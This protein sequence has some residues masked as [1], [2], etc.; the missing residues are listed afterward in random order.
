MDASPSDIR[1]VPV[2]VVG[3]G[4]N[5]IGTFR[6]LCL[7]G[8][9]CLLV[10]RGDL[11]GGASA[12]SSRLMHGGL[13]YLET[14]EFRLVRQSAEERNL[15]LRNA[16]HAVAPLET[17]LPVRS[18]FGGIVPSAR[19]FLGLKARLN[20]RGRLITA[21]GLTLYDIFGRRFRA[22]PVHRFVGRREAQRLLPG[23]DPGILAVGLYYEA[24]LDHAE[25]LGLE[26]A[27]DALAD[28]PGSGIR[29]YC[30]ARGQAGGVIEIEDRLTGRRERVT[31]D[32]VV[33]AGGAW[34]DDVNAALGLNSRYMGGTKG[35]H[36]VVEHPGLLAA[37]NGR[38]VYFGSA[39]GRVNLL[40]PFK[41]RVLIGSTDIPVAHPDEAEVSE[42]E[43]GY[44][45]GVVA[46]VFPNMAIGREDVVYSFCGVRP[47]PRADVDNPGEISRDHSFGEDKLPGTDVPVLSLIGGKWTTYRGFSE[48]AADRVLGHLGRARRASTA[49]LA[50]GGGR[51]FPVDA[52]GR[53]K[54]AAELDR[55]ARAS[56]G[57]RLLLR[58]GTR[59][60]PVAEAIGASDGATLRALPDYHDAEIRWIA[61]HE[62]VR[63]AD[64]ILRRRTEIALTGRAS[65]A[66]HAEVEAIIE[67]A[68]ATLH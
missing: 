61:R 64:D 31:T 37:L 26:I 7:Q 59:A 12:A 57:E 6:D 34:I 66:A 67:S 51:D 44:M 55:L 68:R 17:A 32:L 9:D 62:L 2:L 1:H 16:P 41:N 28:N 54:L 46:E 8:V 23:L 60:R 53:A 56:V 30:T 22:M 4:I 48:E 27:L 5:G 13:K 39:D 65:E 45:I 14:G 43:I 15:L 21:L 10:D 20:D 38:M 24:R 36:V 33:N 42:D 11:C 49:D 52:R 50:I 29:T 63:T 40:Y 58:Y 47:L 3:G 18:W 35:S 25:R 19:R